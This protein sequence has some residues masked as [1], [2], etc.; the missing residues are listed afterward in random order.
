MRVF[1]KATQTMVPPLATKP[2]AVFVLRA[3]FR[4][5]AYDI[6]L[7][8]ARLILTDSPIRTTQNST[9][10]GTFVLDI[11]T[12]NTAI[13]LLAKANCVDEALAAV[14]RTS[15][16]WGLTPDVYTYGAVIEGLAAPGG[17]LDEAL[18]LVRYMVAAQ[19]IAP[20]VVICNILVQACCR[21]GRLQEAWD[22]FQAIPT[23]ERSV[24]RTQPL[25]SLATREGDVVVVEGLLEEL[26]RARDALLNQQSHTK[27]RTLPAAKDFLSKS[28][29]H[30]SLCNLARLG[31]S[32]HA[33]RL[34][35]LCKPVDRKPPTPM[36]FYAL[37]AACE[38]S[39]HHERVL[40]WFQE[41]LCA[42]VEPDPLRYGMALK[43]CEVLGRWQSGLALML[44][45]R[46]S[47]QTMDPLLWKRLFLL[48][49]REARGKEALDLVQDMES[50]GSKLEPICYE[51][52]VTALSRMGDKMQS[53][54]KLMLYEEERHMPMGRGAYTSAIA[55]CRDTKDAELALKLYQRMKG[56]GNE[57]P[58]TVTRAA[59]LDVLVAAGG[60]NF[61]QWAGEV[62]SEQEASGEVVPTH[63]LG[64]MVLASI[65][66]STDV[67]DEAGF[68]KALEYFRYL[69]GSRQDPA[70]PLPWTLCNAALRACARLGESQLALEVLY[71]MRTTKAPVD[72][73]MF[74]CV[75]TSCAVAGEWKEAFL[76]LKDMERTAKAAEMAGL[77]LS[78]I[79][80]PNLVCYTSV[81]TA[82][83][84][85][86][87]WQKALHLLVYMLSSGP[88]PDVQVF[89]AVMSACA[90]AGETHMALKVFQAMQANGV[91]PDA[92]T[93]ATAIVACW[94]GNEWRRALEI[95]QRMKADGFSPN[96]ITVTLVI[97]ALDKSRKF[98]LAV[99]VFESS[100]VGYIRSE[101]YEME[102]D[103]PGM[104]VDLHVS[105]GFYHF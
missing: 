28:C 54:R 95:L 68:K 43:A 46:D 76:L 35:G 55:A 40:H 20:N 41:M 38:K 42:K 7:P 25:W 32:D 22:L 89:N 69:W 21:A 67:S 18:A 30:T 82:L 44:R 23:L 74:G 59:L 60:A 6:G 24:H 64:N 84:Q 79:V 78:D 91:A 14:E 2:A 12:V 104:L 5:A 31:L 99:H 75:L 8:F 50:R 94:R 37:V 100:V 52:T 97:D 103:G 92:V 88:V 87:Q 51:A 15:T 49:G 63:M 83:Q 96:M 62:A 102:S 93:Y 85:G 98:D 61:L 17:N 39:G 27:S 4:A 33:E 80:R 48:L 26:A 47:G 34:A 72:V 101:D 53:V 16:C 73:V 36:T 90:N 13:S 105:G 77:D 19:S 81:I 29:Y 56:R 9:D 86:Q 58:S 45:M 57:A 65:A 71:T 3:C 1:E 70:L 66:R 11:A 10:F